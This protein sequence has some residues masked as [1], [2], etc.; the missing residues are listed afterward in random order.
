MRDFVTR[1][2]VVELPAAGH[3]AAQRWASGTGSTHRDMENAGTAVANER[4]MNDGEF[5]R[6]LWFRSLFPSAMGST[7]TPLLNGHLLFAFQKM[8]RGYISGQHLCTPSRTF[9]CSCRFQ[10]TPGKSTSSY[11]AETTGLHRDTRQVQ[12]RAHVY[13]FGN[14]I[15]YGVLFLTRLAAR[16]RRDLQVVSHTIHPA[17][18]PFL[19]CHEKPLCA[20]PYGLEQ[21]RLL[22]AS[23]L[24]Q[25]A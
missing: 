9:S 8:E 18:C 11:P 17:F 24:L 15:G 13:T 16:E 5:C 1:A 25:L 4:Q 19:F 7:R 10:Q 21:S 6:A 20:E 3:P 12:G 14:C 2:E 22:S 23:F